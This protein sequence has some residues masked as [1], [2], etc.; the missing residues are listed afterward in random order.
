[1]TN[2]IWFPSWGGF[3]RRSTIST[4]AVHRLPA[5]V[6]TSRHSRGHQQPYRPHRHPW[7]SMQWQRFW[8]KAAGSESGWCPL[9]SFNEWG[10]LKCL[11][12]LMKKE[13]SL[14][15]EW[16]IVLT[17]LGL[18]RGWKHVTNVGLAPHLEPVF[19]L[20]SKLMSHKDSQVAS[21]S[22]QIHPNPKG[23]LQSWKPRCFSLEPHGPYKMKVSWPI[24]W[25][26]DHPSPK[27][28]L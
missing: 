17:F 27:Q 6:P 24:K 12:Y 21:K 26:V 15:S 14:K 11:V 16:F 18:N 10:F 3:H 1:M 13:G 9:F 23:S 20:F 25:P 22:I 4:P 28:D 7:L 2:W 8:V 19:Q 5:I